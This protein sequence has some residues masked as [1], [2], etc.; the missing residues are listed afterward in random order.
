[1]GGE[2]VRD[3][4]GQFYCK[5]HGRET[6][7]ECQFDCSMPNRTIEEDVGLRKKRTEVEIV[8]EQKAT[9]LAVLRGEVLVSPR[10]REEVF[11]MHRE[12]LREFDE[13]LKRF[14]KA[15]EDVEGFLAKA[16]DKEMAKEVERLA[17]RQ[18]LLKLNPG[19]S[20]IRLGGA[21]QQN[22]FD[23]LISAPSSDRGS[24]AEK[25][26][27]D[28]CGANSVVKLQLC[29]RCRRKV[30]YCNKICQTVAWKAHKKQ[31]VKLKSTKKNPK[32]L[33]LT[34][35]QVEA[36][37]GAPVE[38]RTLEVRA[39]LDESMM[40]HVFS[41]KDRAGVIR[42]VAAYT[43]SR[44]IPGMRQGAV[45]RWKNPRYYCFMDGSSGARIEEEDLANI[46]IL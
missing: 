34:W 13:Q 5:D 40:R 22:I 20:K 10:P 25:F 3:K 37:E 29:G 12:F 27:C 9:V 14:A 46:T 21:D 18:A 28:Y 36:H 15:G 23:D 42:R 41:C 33:D 2:L 7:D 17:F 11:E 31:C 19:E 44:K 4:Y 43:D 35:D 45:L 32:T 39:I 8:A 26:T 38:G 24:K 1:M 16:I 30:V 6:C